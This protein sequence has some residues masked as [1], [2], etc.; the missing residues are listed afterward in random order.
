MNVKTIFT[1]AFAATFSL[2]AAEY[3][4]DSAH[5]SAGFSVKHMMVSTVK[6]QF[7][8]V[9]GMI[10]YDEKDPGATSVEATIDVTTINTNELKRDTHLKSPD[11]FEVEKFPAMTFK[12]KKAEKGGRGLLLTGEL[13]MH[14]VTKEVVLDVEVSQEMKGM[15]PNTFVR[16]ANATTKINRKDFGLNWNRALD[17]GGVVVS[18]EVH[19]SIDIEANRAVAAN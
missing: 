13:S 4:I 6:G 2:Q 10:N 8:K 5:S 18:D 9:A 17:A 3:K 19:V 7:S 1:V 14:G 15:R 16:G 12:S 11:F